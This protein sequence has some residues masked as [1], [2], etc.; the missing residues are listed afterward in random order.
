MRVSLPSSESLVVAN[1]VLADAISVAGLPETLTELTLEVPTEA[2]LHA[3][4]I[5]LQE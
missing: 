2:N 4:M 3:Q 5:C 1:S